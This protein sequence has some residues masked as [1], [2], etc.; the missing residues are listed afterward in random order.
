MIAIGRLQKSEKN[1]PAAPEENPAA[2]EGDVFNACTTASRAEK[3][4][5]VQALASQGG[6]IVLR[7]ALGSTSPADHLTVSPLLRGNNPYP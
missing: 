4:S 2:L 3:A 6:G 5:T 7:N 1:P